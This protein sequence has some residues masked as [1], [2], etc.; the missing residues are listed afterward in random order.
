M[1]Y[2][3]CDACHYCFEAESLH[4]RCPDCGKTD[5]QNRPAIRP[6]TEKEVQDLLRARDEEWE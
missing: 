2:Y 4:E 5:Y 6:A 1:N 3:F